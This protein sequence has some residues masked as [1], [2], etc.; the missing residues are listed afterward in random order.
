MDEDLKTRIIALENDMDK[1]QSEAK[2]REIKQLRWGVTVLGA[3][4]LALGGWVWSQV[5]PLISLT[6]GGDK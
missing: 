5:E 2:E 1:L 6:V 3:I 4:V